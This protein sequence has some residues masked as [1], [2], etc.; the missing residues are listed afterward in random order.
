MISIK[1]IRTNSQ[2]IEKALKS[3]G[4]DGSINDIISLDENFRKVTHRL[5]QLRAK[6]NT[7]SEMVA[8][9]KR[10]GE[11]SDE[12][13]KEMRDLGDEI[14]ILEAESNT[15]KLDLISLL[16]QVPNLPHQSVPNGTD[17]NDNVI[18]REWGD[19]TIFDFNEKTH[20]ELSALLN[21]LDLERGAKISGSGF[22]I[23]VGKGAELERI[24]INCMI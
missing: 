22:P 15:I 21:L 19:K 12:I 16:E 13:I 8:L 6:K 2:N 7:V 24:L 3:K 14:K 1:D 9:A 17:E 20:L 18:I 5:E 11:N 23:Y 4:Y 10:N